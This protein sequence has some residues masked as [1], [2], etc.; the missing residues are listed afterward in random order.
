M[1]RLTAPSLLAAALLLG[2]GPAPDSGLLIEAGPQHELRITPADLGRF[3]RVEERVSFEG[4]H[5][6]TTATYAGVKLWTLLEQAGGLAT[7]PRDR[8]GKVLIATGRDGYT[9]ALAL[10]ELD[11]TFE[12]KEVLIAA[13]ADGRPM[14]DGGLRLVV[15]GDQRGGRSV[16]D[17]VRIEVR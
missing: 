5:G 4:E 3:P 17:V 1:R 7:M 15:P 6:R 12:G 11:P 8:A 16:R 13:M 14:A 10:G 2:A 9:A